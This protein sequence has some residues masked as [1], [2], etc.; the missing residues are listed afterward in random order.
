MQGFF[1]REGG[2]HGTRSMET[3]PTAT[4]VRVRTTSHTCERAGTEGESTRRRRRRCDAVLRSKQTHHDREQNG[5]TSSCSHPST[6]RDT[7][8]T[9]ILPLP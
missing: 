5:T 7:N 4:D 9:Q 3:G 8:T 2:T 1:S 6:G